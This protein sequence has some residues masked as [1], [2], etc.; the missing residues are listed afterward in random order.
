[1]AYIEYADKYLPGQVYRSQYGSDPFLQ[2]VGRGRSNV[3]FT[4]GEGDSM[5]SEYFQRFL[6]L[7]RNPSSLYEEAVRYPE[8]FTKYM[9]MVREFGLNPASV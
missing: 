8:G 5:S 3:K 6:N 2:V 1:M 7:Q 9:G 4:P